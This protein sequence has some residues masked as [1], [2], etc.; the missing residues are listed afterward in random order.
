MPDNTA[1]LVLGMLIMSPGLITCSEDLC[2]DIFSGWDKLIFT[3]ISR[4]WEDD[5]PD[6]IPLPLL[7]DKLGNN[8]P[9][10]YVS[11]LIDG[12]ISVQPDGF[13]RLVKE[14][15]RNK[16]ARAIVKVVKDGEQE[17]VKTGEID[18]DTLTPLIDKYKTI[19][20]KEKRVSEDIRLWV[21][22]TTGE[23]SLPMAYKELGAKT[24]QEQG[25]VRV[26]LHG[27]V[28]DNLLIPVGRG[29]GHY[30]RVEKELEEVD[31]MAIP[32]EPL[33]LYL[34]L[35]LDNLVKIFSR[36]IIV[37]A[38]VGNM[39][40]SCLGYDFIKNN[41]DNHD[42]HLFFSEGDAGSL[43]ERVD[44]HQDR[45]IGQW[46]FRAYPRTQ[47]FEDVIFGDAINVI[48]YLL[49]PDKFWLVGEML[50]NIYRKLGKGIA[51]VNLQKDPKTEAGRGGWFGLERPQ[52][53]VTLD[54][55][56]DIES[57]AENI[58]PCIAKILKAKSWKK[59]Y[60]PDGKVMKFQI[61]DGWK[62]SHWNDWGYPQKKEKKSGEGQFH[63]RR[64]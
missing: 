48:D 4:L 13:V 40:K 36:S 5:Q 53:Y 20:E 9:A 17:I 63:P 64:Y 26:V 38:G 11:A 32:P 23:F 33:K 22:T 61:E 50:D 62:I 58:Q 46:R 24:T 59:K 21:F 14:L 60:N 3:A 2:E 57:P 30:R 55:D 27:M 1:R 31:L 52:L 12:V 42:I 19:G 8:V 35:G 39:G 44:Q 15:A 45:M 7:V 34:P 41:M 49:V 47:N 29:Y 43:R 28:K 16:I 54:R 6:I 56:H 37:V 25:L 18:L 10:S 51:Y